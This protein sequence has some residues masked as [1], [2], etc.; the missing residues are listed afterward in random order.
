MQDVTTLDQDTIDGIPPLV[1]WHNPQPRLNLGL[2][3]VPSFATDDSEMRNF[4]KSDSL[5]PISMDG[6]ES[7]PGLA[8]LSS[9]PGS[10][11]SNTSRASSL[12]LSSVPSNPTPTSRESLRTNSISVL[13]DP[14]TASSWGYPENT[15]ISQLKSEV[16]GDLGHSR[17]RSAS[18]I[19]IGSDGR[20]VA[21]SPEA[22]ADLVWTDTAPS[23]P[24]Q[25]LFAPKYTEAAAAGSSRSS[26]SERSRALTSTPLPSRFEAQTLTAEFIQYIH[27]VLPPAYSILPHLFSRFCQMVY[28]SPTRTVSDAPVSMPMARFHV[29]LAMAIA[30]KLRIRN[31]SED[32]NA[33]LN[34]CYQ[35]AMQQ[36]GMATFWQ[37]DAG[38]E[39][40]QLLVVFAS[41]R[42]T[43]ISHSASRHHSFSW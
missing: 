17:K 8:L 37:E 15:N 32:T 24:R 20:S 40:A 5:P 1:D 34:T 10:V 31:S 43:S 33:L 29:F 26:F 13:V 27:N 12:P 11:W 2:A 22:E 14:H 35:L 4:T 25:G 39:A 38:Q 23:L 6:Y 42:K 21:P 30:M 41:I 18:S 28:P 36:S 3:V 7:S 19:S 9:P 16:A